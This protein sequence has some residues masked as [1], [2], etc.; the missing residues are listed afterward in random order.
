MPIFVTH[1]W[2]SKL[3]PAANAVLFDGDCE[4]TRQANSDPAPELSGVAVGVE[5]GTV[6]V[7][8]MKMK[9]GVGDSVGG[10]VLVGNKVTVAVNVGGIINAV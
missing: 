1:Q 9:V 5:D 8:S 2:A 6:E 4:S 7:G 3:S 10:G